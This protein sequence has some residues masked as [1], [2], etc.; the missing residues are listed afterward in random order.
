MHLFVLFSSIRLVELFPLLL[1]IVFKEK[2]SFQHMGFCLLHVELS[3][4]YANHLLPVSVVHL[5]ILRIVLYYEVKCSWKELKW[6]IMTVQI[7]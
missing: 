1:A 2:M 4:L 3:A 7:G 5:L 6:S